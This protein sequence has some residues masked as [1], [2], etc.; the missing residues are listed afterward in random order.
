MKTSLVSIILLL[1]FLNISFSQ[2][3]QTLSY[4][5]VL[6]DASGIPVTDGDY[7][8]TFRLYESE[9]GGTAIWTEGQTITLIN[10]LFN[11][12]LGK[13]ISYPVPFDKPYWLGITIDSGS[14]LS[15]RIELT[16]SA[17]SLNS[18][19]VYGNS[20]VFPSD[21]NV[22][23]GTKDPLAHLQVKGAWILGASDGFPNGVDGR[24]Y[25]EN[26]ILYEGGG[27][28][29]AHHLSAFRGGDIAR[30][31]TG[32]PGTEPNTK[33]VIKNDGRVG[34]GTTDPLHSLEVTDTIY[35]SFGGFKFPD[36][37][38]QTTAATGGNGGGG[39]ITAVTAGQGL[40]GGG[41][42]GDVVLNVGTGSGLT[43]TE[44]QI[45]LDETYTDARYVNEGQTGSVTN[46]MISENAVGSLEVA[47]NSLSSDDLAQNSVGTS[48]VSD[49]SL[50][51][52]DLGVNVISSIDGV[53]NDGGNIDLVEGSNITIV[54]DNAGNRITISATG[55]F[56]LPYSGTTVSSATAFSVTTTGT[57]R[58]GYFRINNSDN[59]NQVIYGETNGMG[60]VGH[61]RIVNATNDMEA[62]A[63]STQGTGPALSGY[64]IGSGPGVYGRTDGDGEAGHFEITNSSSSSHAVYASTAGSGSGVYGKSTDGDGVYGF[65]NATS[66]S[67]VY[68][69]NDN[70]QGDGVAGSSTS[71]RGV[72]G[73]SYSG[74]AVYAISGYGDG[75]YGQSSGEDKAGIY[76]YNN[77]VGGYGVYG[78]ST[79]G[80]ALYG[81]G[82]L[83]CTGSK[84]AKVKLDNGTAVRLY[85]E[86]SA[87]SWF[88]DYGEGKLSDSH[89]H[90]ELDQL[91]LQTVTI[92]AE[93]PMKVFVQVEGDC[94]GV[95][96]TNKTSTGFDV[97]EL[98]EGGSN[99]PFSYRVV[100][101]RKY[102]ED[103]RLTTPEEN[104]RST[105]RMMELAW[106]EIITTHR[107]EETRPD[108]GR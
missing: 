97:V 62:V 42:T 64:T 78:W 9:T 82:D 44:N 105:K 53:S 63:A 51:V 86:E 56:T 6:T 88:S 49:N 66:Q 48:E 85:A 33:V 108:P 80:I 24:I 10:G 23:I 3:P 94:N 93:N 34:I 26:G 87:E 59:S 95:Y 18:R 57:G 103:N 60:R 76:G 39:D 21:G 61:F 11:V 75:V 8:L 28:D 41:E 40:T 30:F 38:V 90:I 58:A 27:T 12:I 70:P 45:G 89:A 43:A 50:L 46:E 101:K 16:S 77:T 54:P 67:G 5:G 71:G 69:I 74:T 84:S 25:A 37:S 83:V 4:Q 107:V 17:Y 68:G 100:C 73:S 104:A 98:Q 2:I 81:H 1:L 31:G 96:V 65:S 106:P 13:A 32:D 14:E 35:S 52:E 22:G 91:F 20:N 92:D 55:G 72:R 99:A 7:T 102:Y 47:D 79:N 36:G 29:W 19:S 15:P